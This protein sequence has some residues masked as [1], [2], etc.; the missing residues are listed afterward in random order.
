MIRDLV[1]WMLNHGFELKVNEEKGKVSIRHLHGVRPPD[2]VCQEKFDEIRERQ[3]EVLA[4]LRMLPI[5]RECYRAWVAAYDDWRAD[6]DPAHEQQ[7]MTNYA[8]AAIRLRVPFYNDA[9]LN[10]GQVGWQLWAGIRP[11][12]SAEP[13]PEVA[14]VSAQ[15]SKPEDFI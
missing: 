11:V 1:Y 3:A 10:L 14:P 4:Y 7:H 9:G 5:F 15:T 12:E 2:E 6:P 8:L 13:T